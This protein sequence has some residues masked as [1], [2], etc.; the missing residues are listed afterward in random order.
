MLDECI[1][2]KCAHAIIEYLRL[3]KPPVEAHFLL[4][5]V[6]EQGQLDVEWS[7]LL[8]PSNEWIV[9]TGDSGSSGPRIHAKGPPLHLIL[10]QRGICGFYLTGKGLT[11][12]TGEERARLI[13]S[14]MPDIISKAC[15]SRGGERYKVVQSAKGIIIKP[16]PLR[17]ASPGDAVANSD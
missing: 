16:W 3:Y 11:Q 5:F 1:T 13:I 17:H 14:K 8:V 4:D 10:P 12:N 2:K 7:T 6:K 15:R 9:V